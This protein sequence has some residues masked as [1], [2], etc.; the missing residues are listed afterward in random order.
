M[1]VIQIRPSLGHA[2]E[3]LGWYPLGVHTSAFIGTCSNPSDESGNAE[4]GPLRPAGLSALVSSP[5]WPSVKF[6]WPLLGRLSGEVI[7]C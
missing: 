3:Q 1:S 6:P 5:T 4:A 7:L 2:G